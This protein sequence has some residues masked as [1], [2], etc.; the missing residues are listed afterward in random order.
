[1][2]PKSLFNKLEIVLDGSVIM[3]EGTIANIFNEFFTNL[4][5]TLPANRQVTN[6]YLSLIYLNP[7]SFFFQPVSSA[8]LKTVLVNMK[9]NSFTH[10]TLPSKVLKAVIDPLSRIL[11]GLFNDCINFSCIPN[12]LKVANAIP[13]LKKG[14]RKL[15][16]NYRTIALLNP[17]TKIF[18]K[19]MYDRIISFFTCENLF[20]KLQF[21][22]LPDR[23]IQE[24]VLNILYDLNVALNKKQYSVVI[25]LDYSKAFD[26]INHDLLLKK[27][28]RYG[29]FHSFFSS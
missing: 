3:D 24:V 12:E 27:L 28:Y 17:I 14:S 20:C 8:E 23:G 4:H 10:S 19:I 29:F 15:N 6:D 18:E 1:M 13:L 21:G 5:L 26:T 22:F 11:C 9:E 2:R 7:H 16:E 25:F